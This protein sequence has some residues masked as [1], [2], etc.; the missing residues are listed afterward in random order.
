MTFRPSQAAWFETYTPRNQTVYAIETLANT[1]IVEL[2]H[3]LWSSANIDSSLIQ[4][5]VKA[6][7]HLAA[8]HKAF[9]PEKLIAPDIN[10]D[11]PE[12]LSEEALAL[13]RKWSADLLRLQRNLARTEKT[14]IELKQ[15]KSLLMAIP[16]HDLDFKWLDKTSDILYKKLFCCPPDQFSHPS[17]KEFFTQVFKTTDHDFLLVLGTPEHINAIDATAT[18]VN[19]HE[20]HIPDW[21]EKAEDNKIHLINQHLR[22]MFAK[23]HS[24]FDQLEAHQNSVPVSYTHLRAHET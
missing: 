4:A 19:C 5:N 22:E 9:L 13:L 17:G 16:D 12:Q 8:K 11:S 14:I 18:L 20:F 1:G 15:L 7:N 6:F 10:H 21:L 24:M 2:S 3:D 23:R